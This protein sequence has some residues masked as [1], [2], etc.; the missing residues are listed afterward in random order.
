MF[1]WFNW[2]KKKDNDEFAPTPVGPPSGLT[3]VVALGM[4]QQ[5]RANAL[6]QGQ[7]VSSPVFVGTP[8]ILS[9]RRSVW[10]TMSY[11]YLYPSHSI[12]KKEGKYSLDGR[13]YYD[14]EQFMEQIR[15][16]IKKDRL[17]G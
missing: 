10:T 7:V 17:N 2:G 5:E 13:T 9:G 6:L 4:Q 3:S 1:S 15:I 8:S 14:T 12:Y 16:M 11:D